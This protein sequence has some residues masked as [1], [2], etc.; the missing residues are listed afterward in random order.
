MVV[1]M[2]KRFATRLEAR[3][4][5]WEKDLA[6]PWTA[7]PGEEARCAKRKAWLT[8]EKVAGKLTIRQDAVQLLVDGKEGRK[9]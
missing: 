2:G 1:L 8:I 7:A 5:R 3:E 6:R 4:E 9:V